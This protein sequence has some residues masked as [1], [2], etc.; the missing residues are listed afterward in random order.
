MKE[1]NINLKNKSGIYIITNL[2]NGNRYI[3][4]SNNIYDRLKY[5]IR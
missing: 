5:H 3:G 2:L 4:S 1:I